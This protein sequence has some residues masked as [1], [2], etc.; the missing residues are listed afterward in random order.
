MKRYF[1]DVVGHGQSELDY[2]GRILQ[3][4]ERAHETAELMA[5]DLAVKREDEAIGWV[6]NVS[7]GEGHKL[8][9]IPVQAS[10]LA[11]A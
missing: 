1:F 11:A 10:Y 2:T 3:T 9:S 6:V 4:P 5:F 8:F 7:S